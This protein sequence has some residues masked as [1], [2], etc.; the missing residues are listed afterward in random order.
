MGID[1]ID[2]VND[3]GEAANPGP[4]N[5]RPLA[6]LFACNRALLPAVLRL[7]RVT[8]DQ[9]IAPPAPSKPFREREQE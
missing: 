4:M 8:R 1:R 6:Y 3:D 2:G 7:A 5:P 9:V